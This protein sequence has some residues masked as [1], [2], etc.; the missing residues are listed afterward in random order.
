MDTMLW[1]LDY[2][3]GF[4]HA[5]WLTVRITVLVILISWVCGL[6]AALGK[7]SHWRV[8][9]W[10]C[11]FYVWFIRGTPAMIQIFAVYFGLPQFG[12]GM[13]PFTA[14]VIT[15]GLNSGAYVAE[16]IRGGLMAIPKGQYE[17]PIALGMSNAQ[18]MRRIIL[19]QVTRIILP[20][21]TNEAVATLKN[22]SLLSAITVVELT[23]HAQIVIART[24]QPFQ[25]YI[26]A[27]LFYL[28]LTT[29]LTR[30]STFLEQ[31][32]ARNG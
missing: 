30:L 31:R 17:S 9:R 26:M 28:V 10:P 21:I 27:A 13:S 16:I 14:G 22:T 1:T 20:S 32:N 19:P 5:A 11:E 24:F 15:L 4:F 12:L 7:R 18:A 2:L 3:P 6:I 29:L 25:F 23:F 8:L